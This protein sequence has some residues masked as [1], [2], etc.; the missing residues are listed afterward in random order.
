MDCTRTITAC[1]TSGTRTTTTVTLSCPAFPDFDEGDPNEAPFIVLQPGD[2]DLPNMIGT[3]GDI[4]VAPTS[5]PP[6]TTTTPATTKTEPLPTALPGDNT[7]PYCFRDD[8]SSGKYKTWKP[9]ESQ[10]LIAA[11][12]DPSDH[13]NPATYGHTSAAADVLIASI[14]W[15]KSQANCPAKDFLPPGDPCILNMQDL[16]LWCD[17][18]AVDDVY[19]GGAITLTTDYGCVTLCLG[20]GQVGGK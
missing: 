13:L 7:H 15:S 12:C 5:T 14:Q 19:M 4:T 2:F 9:S 8:I 20:T 16:Y 11:V 10:K 17:D 18:G 6:C 1:S 3:N